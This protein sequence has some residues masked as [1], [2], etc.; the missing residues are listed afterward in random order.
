M[1]GLTKMS[2]DAISLMYGGGKCMSSRAEGGVRGTVGRLGCVPDRL[3]HG[4][5]VRGSKV[6]KVVIPSVTRPF[7]DAFVGC[8][9]GRL[10]SEKCGTLIY[11][12]TK[13]RSMRRTCL[14]VLS[15][16]AVSN[17]VVKTRSLGGREC[18]GVSEP[19]MAVSYCLTSCVPAIRMSGERI[20]RG[21]TSLFLRGGEG[22]IMRLMDSRAVGGC[23]GRGRR[24][25]RRLLRGRKYRIMSVSVKCGAFATRNC[26]ST[27]RHVFR[28]YDSVSNVF[29]IS[30]TTVTY[31]QRTGLEGL[32]IPRR[33]D[34]IS[35]SKACVAGLKPRVLAS[36]IR[37]VRGVTGGLI[38][39]VVLRVRKGRMRRVGT[40]FSIRVRSK[41][42]YWFSA[43]LLSLVY[44]GM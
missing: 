17:I 6:M 21:T 37:P 1:T 35:V 43:G 42:A 16:E 8:T 31:L 11:K 23:R 33:L 5:G 36:V 34:V 32:G 12:A 26:G 15:H 24:L 40:V 10:C 41:R 28:R 25:F 18:L 14:R 22:G 2:E 44:E 30:V 4:L 27:T 20:T 13:H 3:N 9:R 7:F 29:N 39:V 38:S 19:V